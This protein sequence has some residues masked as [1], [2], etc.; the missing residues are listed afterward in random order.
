MIGNF[1]NFVLCQCLMARKIAELFGLNPGVLPFY[2]ACCFDEL[3]RGSV[4]CLLN[5]SFKTAVSKCHNS[6]FWA[7]INDHGVHRGNTGQIL[8]PWQHMVTSKV[9]LDL[10]YWAMCL[11]LHRLIHMTIEMARKAG[12]FFS[13]IDFM[14]CI[15][16]AKRPCYGPLKLKPSYI[17]VHYYVI[18]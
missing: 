18:S 15:T 5:T 8:A 17:I 14:S 10:P 13:F 4:L 2:A 16:V 7:K 11:A 6:T 9:A 1:A 12:P 3:S